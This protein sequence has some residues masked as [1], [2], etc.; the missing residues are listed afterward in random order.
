VLRRLNEADTE[1][2]SHNDMKW[3]PDRKLEFYRGPLER[4]EEV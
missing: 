3:Y 2:L 4:Y 1:R